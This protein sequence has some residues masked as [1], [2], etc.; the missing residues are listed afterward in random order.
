VSASSSTTRQ[1]ARIGVLALAILLIAPV[2]ALAARTWSEG[3]EARPLSVDT[4]TDVVVTPV[5]GVPGAALERQIL[6]EYRPPAALVFEPFSIQS[7]PNGNVLIASR[8]N[9][10]LEV[11]RAN[12]IV[13]SYTRLADNPDLINVYSAQR[14]PNGNTLITDRRA[15]FII[16]V[17]PAKQIVWRYGAVFESLTPGSV[18][19]PFSAMRLPNGN[20]LITDNR[21]ATRVLEVRSSDYDPAA[22]NLGYTE[23]SIVWRYGRDNDGGTGP[24]QLASP[25]FAQRLANG[26]TLITDSADQVFGGH[27]VIEITPGGQIVWQ[28]GQAGIPGTEPG[29]L[30]Q[31]S[32]AI[33]LEN[34]NTII[35]EEGTSR[36]LEVDLDG[37]IVD[38]YGPGEFTP[39]GGALGA[40][41]SLA[42]TESGAT[43]IADQGNQRVIE[44]GY[45]TSGILVSSDLMLDLPGVKKTIGRF[46]VVAEEPPGTS[47][48]IAYSLDGG[49]WVS[50]GHTVTPPA[51]A[52]ATRVKYRLTF[53]SDSAAYTPVV[54]EVRIDYD[55]A[56]SD[57]EPPAGGTESD[58]PAAGPTQNGG[59]PASAG[60]TRR[61]A[62]QRRSAS[63][64]T[65]GTGALLAPD[66]AGDDTASEPLSGADTVNTDDIAGDMTYA[67]GTLFASTA[68]DPTAGLG[69]LG[70]PVG[71][72]GAWRAL[73]VLAVS[74]T[75]GLGSAPTARAA[76]Q[77]VHA[78]VVLTGWR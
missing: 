15:D 55:V 18:V 54:R 2:S 74:Y 50:G 75:I 77:L 73:I 69:S 31:P 49:P 17:N 57:T 64:Q 33:R 10:V 32:T 19:D 37:E 43:L 22:P 3:T 59:S 11:T 14:L 67:R 41:R 78:T 68:V 53:S 42:R 29:L 26:N 70:T 6:W 30:R 23:D 13:W 71:P 61:D 9:E 27:R 58:P 62:R 36:V 56:P 21:F 63:T 16:E 72:A 40:T 5:R 7:L 47:V 12:R 38:L 45:A 60:G 51:G 8:T 24:G 48:S 25:R 44:I 52:T 76:R 65:P 35:T 34:G 1:L 20:T 46:E 4:A 28:Y 66:G 39:E